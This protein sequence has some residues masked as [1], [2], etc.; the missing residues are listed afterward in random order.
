MLMA[1]QKPHRYA[2]T[3]GAISAQCPVAPRKQTSRSLELLPSPTPP[4][5]P[6]APP[7]SRAWAT[8]PCPNIWLS[9]PCSTRGHGRCSIGA[10]CPHLARRL[11]R[12]ALVC[13][14]EGAHLMKTEQPRNLGYMQ[15]AVLEVTDC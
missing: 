1:S 12:P 15:L 10:S 2:N 14:R 5:R 3:P 6:R 11:A 13:V 8:G 7:R 9:H 4:S